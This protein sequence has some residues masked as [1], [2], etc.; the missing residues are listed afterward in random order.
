MSMST[1]DH[2]GIAVHVAHEQQQNLR[3]L[4]LPPILLQLLTSQP[5]SKYVPAGHKFPGELIIS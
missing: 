3:L 5:A 2:Q 1:Q 4:E